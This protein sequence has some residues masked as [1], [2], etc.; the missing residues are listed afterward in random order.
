MAY[1]SATLF[2]GLNDVH[3]GSTA[4]CIKARLIRLYKQPA[5][6]NRNEVGSM[7]LV[8]HDKEGV[9]IHV[10]MKPN[11]YEKL[12][13]K[14]EKEMEEGSVYII[15]NFLV[16]DNTTSF[17][18]THHNHKLKFFRNTTMSLTDE[19]FPSHITTSLHLTSSNLTI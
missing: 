19:E 16:I 11:I 13:G 15:K 10:T 1:S 9:R 5:Y 8:I 17:R 12:T 18:T 2:S 4:W 3:S 14:M 6:L 7:E